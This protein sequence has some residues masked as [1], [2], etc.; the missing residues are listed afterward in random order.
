V[1]CLQGVIKKLQLCSLV[2]L[3]GPIS[4]S[5]SLPPLKGQDAI[6][7]WAPADY[8]VIRASLFRYAARSRCS[9]ESGIR[10]GCMQ[11][12]SQRR[13][14]SPE[15]GSSFPA[16][17]EP[18]LLNSLRSGKKDSDRGQKAMLQKTGK[19]PG[20]KGHARSLGN[21]PLTHW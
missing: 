11:D 6:Y 10:L 21:S 17:P 1:T 19:S 8:H 18:T 14:Q 13:C 12:F 4:P 7:S 16:R 2:V 3:Q 9:S 20:W 5:S 15:P